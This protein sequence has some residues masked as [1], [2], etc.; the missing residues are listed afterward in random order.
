[1]P[2]NSRP[3]TSPPA[4]RVVDVHAARGH[5]PVQECERGAGQHDRHHLEHHHARP[6][7]VARE[8]QRESDDPG[9]EREAGTDQQRPDGERAPVDEQPA[10]QRPRLGYAPDRVEGAVDGEHHH[11]GG[12]AEDGE[13]HRGELAGV[14]RE[15]L[16]V[17]RDDP[18][19]CRG[20]QVLEDEVADGAGEPG[21]HREGR[22]HRERDRQQRHQGQQRREGQAA[23]D[24]GQPIL[25]HAREQM[26]GKLEGGAKLASHG[27]GVLEGHFS[28][29]SAGN[30][31]LEAYGAGPR[32]RKCLIGRHPA[33]AAGRRCQEQANYRPVRRHFRTPE[34]QPLLSVA[35]VAHRALVI[36]AKA[37]IQWNPRWTLDSGSRRK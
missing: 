9:G 19:R 1:M 4:D 2:S 25:P 34:L 33:T 15:L 20:N 37:G 23:R 21:E 22:E 26:D 32:A 30:E 27:Q 28:I 36:P 17:H 12:H 8:L 13:T 10:H 29:I 7:D 5:G 14:L 16:H 11:H 24:L 18:P 6:A 3:A 35:E 31:A